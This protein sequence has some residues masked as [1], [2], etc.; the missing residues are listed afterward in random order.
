MLITNSILKYF[1]K[2]FSISKGICTERTKHWNDYVHVT[3][4]NGALFG[5]EWKAESNCRL[6]IHL[7]M[8]YHVQNIICSSKLTY[9]Y[10]LF[11]VPPTEQPPSVA[12]FPCTPDVLR[13]AMFWFMCERVDYV[14]IQQDIIRNMYTYMYMD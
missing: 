10:L 8:Y 3:A 13:G 9:I 14:G 11:P 12:H 2:A 1:R 7:Y 4:C 5:G 6:H